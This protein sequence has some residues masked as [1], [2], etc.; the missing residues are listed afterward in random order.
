VETDSERGVGTVGP[1]AISGADIFIK[2]KASWRFRLPAPM[3]RGKHRSRSPRHAYGTTRDQAETAPR[4]GHGD[5]DGGAE[6]MRIEQRRRFED[7]WD[8]TCALDP[9]EPVVGAA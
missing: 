1:V 6:T 5:L 7:A 9:L 4:G 3:R 2:A 8:A